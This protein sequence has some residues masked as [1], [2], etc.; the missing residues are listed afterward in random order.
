MVHQQNGLLSDDA[1]TRPWDGASYECSIAVIGGSTAAYTT[2]LTALRLKLDVC[3]VQPQRMVGGQ[4]TAQALPASDDGDLL[5]QQAALTTLDGE[6]FAISKSQRR[7]RNRQR[8]LQPVAGRVVDDPGG[9]WVCP[10]SATPVVASTA[11]NERLLPYLKAG[12]LM[13]IPYA[14]PTSLVL[15]ATTDTRDTRR[16]TGVMC[17]DTKT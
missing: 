8:Q 12:K 5:R 16:V 13:L 15:A 6:E 4:F 14:E 7:F 1:L 2:A 9:S 3:L 11:L 10:L 17:Q